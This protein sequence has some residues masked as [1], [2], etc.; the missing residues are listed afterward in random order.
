MYAIRLGVGLLPGMVVAVAL[1]VLMSKLIDM[2]DAGLNEEPGIKIADITMPDTTIEAQIDEEKPDKPDEVEEPPP[3]I[4]Q[5]EIDLDAPTDALN[6]STGA[7][8]F[9]PEIGIGGGFARDSDYI[10]VYVP[11]PRYPSRAEKSGKTG[12]AVVEVTITTSGGVRDVKLVEEWPENYGF[13]REAVKAAAKLKYN[14][15]MVDGVGVEVPG[16]LYKF[17]FAGFSD[18]K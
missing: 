17:T 10:P 15:R 12:Y 1:F 18:D 11:A 5:Q 4:Q 8:G 7:G 13:G 9:T 16:V 14:P 3:E 6:I 2:G